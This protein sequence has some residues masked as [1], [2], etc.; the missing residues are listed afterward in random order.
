MESYLRCF[1]YDKPKTWSVWLPWAVYWFNT[2]YNASTHSTPFKIVYGKDPPT[3]IHFHDD[4][5]AVEDVN[6]QL[7]LH[8]QCLNL[9]KD[10][11]VKALLTAG[12]CNFSKEI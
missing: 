3:I 7:R 2:T 8:N 9:L 11:W 12:N 6:V 1:A 4:I 5:S 10:N